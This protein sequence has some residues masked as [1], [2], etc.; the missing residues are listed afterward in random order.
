MSVSF[1]ERIRRQQVKPQRPA[2]VLQTCW[3]DEP[4]QW[5]IPTSAVEHRA[6]RPPMLHAVPRWSSIDMPMAGSGLAV[7]RKVDGR[8]EPP[9]GLPDIDQARLH[10][11]IPQ[12]HCHPNVL[13][14]IQV[15]APE[16]L[17]LSIHWFDLCLPGLD[18]HIPRVSWAKHPAQERLDES[19]G[20]G[21]QHR[22]LIRVRQQVAV[23]AAI[24]IKG[25]HPFDQPPAHHLGG[26]EVGS[27]QARELLH[28]HVEA[29]GQA[30]ATINAVGLDHGSNL[31]SLRTQ[32]R[33]Q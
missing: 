32:A 23:H 21:P 14:T 25:V 1:A 16:L 18:D 29:A 26:V 28:Q 33:R 4:P 22:Q 24:H 20:E 12:H 11:A 10:E 17:Q 13:R 30:H 31:S 3:N 5:T 27:S 8:N 7:M 2:G 6:A 15:G 9:S 19:A